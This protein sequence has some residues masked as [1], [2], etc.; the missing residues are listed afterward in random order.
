MTQKIPT[1]FHY[2]TPHTRN[3]ADSH[4]TWRW[5]VPLKLGDSI[6]LW[7]ASQGY[8]LKKTVTEFVRAADFD[9]SPGALFFI[10][11]D[12]IAYNVDQ[13]HHSVIERV[14][15]TWLHAHTGKSAAEYASRYDVKNNS[16]I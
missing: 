11:G 16:Q 2:I 3:A 12:G 7:M 15:G 8:Y 9:G 14:N 4:R 10:S 1:P 13:H 6:Y 5:K